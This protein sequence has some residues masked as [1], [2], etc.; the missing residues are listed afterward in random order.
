MARRLEV[1]EQLTADL[2][3]RGVAPR[4]VDVRFPEAPYYSLT[5]DW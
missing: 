3:A 1:L 4:F 5:N 2:E